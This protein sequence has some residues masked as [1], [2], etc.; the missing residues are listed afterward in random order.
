ME[1]GCLSVYA[2]PDDLNVPPTEKT[3]LW[4]HPQSHRQLPSEPC[5]RYSS[6]PLV[7]L[8][9]EVGADLVEIES[10]DPLADRG[11]IEKTP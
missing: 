2:P 6:C 11:L 8:R 7:L 5:N 9:V 4:P 10:A 1:P 3:T